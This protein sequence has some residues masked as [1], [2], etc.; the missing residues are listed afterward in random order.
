MI[1]FMNALQAF[2]SIFALLPLPFRAFIV[3]FGVIVIGLSILHILTTR[4]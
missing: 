4:T 3:T 1:P 2:M